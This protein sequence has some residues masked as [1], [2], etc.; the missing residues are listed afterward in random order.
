M[1]RGKS[2]TAPLLKAADPFRRAEN[3]VHNGE[4]ALERAHIA[5]ANAEAAYLDVVSPSL[6]ARQRLPAQTGGKGPTTE[7]N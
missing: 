5:R 4:R 2:K 3:R 1:P 7:P 6:A